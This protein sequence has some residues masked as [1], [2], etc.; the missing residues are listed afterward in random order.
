MEMN[1][2]GIFAIITVTTLFINNT[3]AVDLTVCTGCHG[4]NF[5]KPAMGIS[6]IVKDLKEDQILTAL[7]G[8]KTGTK[9]GSMQ[10]VMSNQISKFDDTQIHEIVTIIK[11]GHIDINNTKNQIDKVT[12]IE[13]NSDKCISCH[14]EMFQKSAMG[15]SRIVNEMSKEDIIASMNGYKN[16][17][18]GGHLKA[19]MAGQVAD[20]ST[21]EIEAFAQLIGKR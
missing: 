20:L 21:E 18:Y 1:K 13:V 19:L 7:Q 16:G 8:Y 14:G 3:F 2:D 11:S 17:T 15:Y 4:R 9:G 6:R 5:E 12:I 10:E